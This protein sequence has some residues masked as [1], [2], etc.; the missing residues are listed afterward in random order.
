MEWYWALTLLI[1][2][3]IFFMAMAVPV[4]FAFMAANLIGALVFIGGTNA[5]LQVVDNSSSMITRFQLAPV[6][7]FI[8]MGSL[9]FHSGLAVRVFDTLDKFL[10]RIPGRLCYLT[11][12][13]GTIFSTLTGSSMA[14]TAMLGSL[15]VPEMQRRGY[16]RRMSLGPILGT[17]GLA[18]IIPPSTLGVLLASLAGIDVG[19]FLI[20]GIGPG[21]LLS[22]LFVVLITIQIWLHPEGTPNYEIEKIDWR[23]ALKEAAVNILPMSLVVFMVIGLIILGV[24]TP[25]ESAAFGVAGV[26]ILAVAF[27]LISLEVI[28]T[29]MLSTVKVSGMVFFIILNSSIFSQLLAYSG[30][31]AG[32]LHYA[33]SFEVS[34]LYMLSAIFVCILILGMFMDPVSI[35]LI[36]VPIFFPLIHALGVNPIWFGIFMLLGLEMSQTTPPFGLLLFVMLGVAPKGT[37]LRQVA[38]AAAPFLICD[39]VVIGIMALFPA[40]VLYLPGLM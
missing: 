21:F 11:V 22:G 40:L 3:V 9:F 10:G 17:G 8:V 19:R 34:R 36:T 24:A 18:M 4:A 5:I 12:A 28:K 31:S 13:G 37:T 33:T 2:M 23:A 25:T 7:F 38:S 29:S 1:G 26:L 32:M 35:M 15:M 16:S 39:L 30:A 6:P 14:N 20:A 27:R